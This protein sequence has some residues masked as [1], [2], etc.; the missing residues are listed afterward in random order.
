MHRGYEDDNTAVGWFLFVVFLAVILSLGYWISSYKCRA[1]WE[2][3]G[4]RSRFQIFAGCQVQTA[5]GKWIPDDRI[6]D[7]NPLPV[8]PSHP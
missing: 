7:L 8:Y 4:T 3:S 6:R 1:R 2:E 5:A